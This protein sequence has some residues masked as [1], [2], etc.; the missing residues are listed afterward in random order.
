[1]AQYDP[2]W[3]EAQYNNRA[4]VA[5]HPQILARWAE[6]SALSRDR[7]SRRLDLRYGEGPQETLDLFPAPRA[8][9][10][11]LVFIHGGYWRALDKAEHSFIAPS[12][13]A[14]GA[15][16]VVPNYD[17]CPAVPIETIALQTTRALA[18]VWRHAALYGGDPSRIV[19]AGHSAGGHLAAM[20]LCCD[21]KSVGRELPARLLR[22]ALSLSG[23]FE[24]D[25]LRYTPF[26]RDDLR[27]TPASAKALSPATF[28]PPRGT[29]HALVG[30]DESEEFVRQNRLIREAWG[31]AAVP[32]CET[33]PGCNH[34]TVL[35]ELATPSSR[36]HGLAL[37]LLGLK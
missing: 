26:L 18:W 15:M 25:P 37:R 22:G 3:L 19:V 20:L 1:M 32:V 4:R 30:A 16:V 33:I 11:V 5:E 28:A 21:W 14:H 12:F 6:A 23:L 9:A 29:L 24:L 17:L 34:F 36:V 10:P 13:V 7:S 35:H 8:N 27:L 31:E 2:A